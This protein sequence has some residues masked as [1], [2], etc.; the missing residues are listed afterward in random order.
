MF[1]GATIRGGRRIGAPTIPGVRGNRTARRDYSL[2]GTSTGSAFERGLV[3]AAWYRPPIAADRLHALTARSN[4][5]AAR[6]TVIWLGLLVATGTWA[7]FAIGTWWAVPAFAAYGALYG[8]AADSRWHEMGHGTA[9]RSAWLNDAVYYLASFMLLREPTLWRWS[10]AR[11]HTDTIV[12]GRDPE[13]AFPRP[14]GWPTT[15]ATFLGVRTI[16]RMVWRMVRHAGGRLDADAEDLVPAHERSKVVWEARAFV[17]ILFGV[18]AWSLLAG[19]IVPLLYVG[20][21]TWYGTWL[22]VFFGVTQHAGLQEDILDHRLNT[23]TVYMNPVFRFLYSN[24]NY[25]VEHH[26]FPTVPYH[27]L[28]A[29]HEE[30]KEHLAPAMP[31]TIAAY[32][33]ILAALRR[34]VVDPTYEIPDRGVPTDDAASR[35]RPDVGEYLWADAYDGGRRDLGAAPELAIGQVRRIDVGDRTFAL[36]RLGAD[37]YALTDGECTHGRT[38]LADGVVLDCRTIECP[39]HNGRF[40]IRTGEP[41]RRPATLPLAT[42]H[43]D[44]VGGRLISDLVPRTRDLVEP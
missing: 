40:D 22:M 30:V 19:T 6:D 32:R 37:D 38:H 31:S 7:W 28:P 13:I 24:M 27:A 34:Q 9:F 16:P 35:R 5:R 41:T 26:I 29:L 43:V 23:R 3:D 33:E 10:H 36:Y 18:A 8:G 2:T 20:L 12:V 15:L 4:A 1:T 44:V 14:A 42:Y 25:H 17:A 21:P 39:K 11:H